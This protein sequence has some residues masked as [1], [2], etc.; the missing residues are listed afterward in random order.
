[1]TARRDFLVEIGTEELPPKSLLSLASAFAEG[2]GKGLD[3]AGLGH[4]R[5]ER[6]ATPRRLAVLVSRVVEQ[7]PDRAVEK[8]G[9]PVK[10]AF[11]AAGAPTAA[12]VAF[13]RGC[14]IEVDR[15]E[16]IQTPK[17]EWLVYRGVE[18]G[19][20][21]L[22][23]LPR[24]VTAALDGL[25]IAR[26][27]RWG[28]GDAEFVRPVHWVTMLFGRDVVDADVL[29]VRAGNITYGH[30]FMAPKPIRL[31][32]P[33]SYVGTLR[34]RGRVLADFDERRESIRSGV[35]AAAAQA[36]GNAVNDPAL[37]DEV[38]AL[39][40]WPVPLTGVFAARYL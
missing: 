21:T 2:V 36:Q 38:T 3:T 34:K 27:M 14:G 24:V 39:V 5:I 7:Q 4:G 12:A 16:R 26:R 15:L 20:S 10:T 18:A 17:G 32:S 1:M 8:R 30:R 6:F 37:L 11:D 19:A 31:R 13:A 35:N 29:G 28:A 23:L 9:P 22:S 40:E 25:P 33:A